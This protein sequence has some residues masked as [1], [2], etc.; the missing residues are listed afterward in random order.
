MPQSRNSYRVF[1]THVSWLTGCCHA[2]LA[3][4][5]LCSGP[6]SQA[7][8]HP[9]PEVPV[10]HHLQ[11]HGGNL[12]VLHLPEL[13]YDTEQAGGRAPTSANLEGLTLRNWSGSDN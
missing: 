13:R 8:G 9:V 3:H 4:C 11:D 5:S 7:G 2:R 12:E 10:P 6:L 1:G